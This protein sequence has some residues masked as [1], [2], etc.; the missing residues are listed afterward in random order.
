[1]MQFQMTLFKTVFTIRI[2]LQCARSDKL[3]GFRQGSNRSNLGNR[4]PLATVAH[5]Q[6]RFIL[7]AVIAVKHFPQIL[8]WT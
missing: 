5:N 1:M 2:F 4:I 8:K 3:Q 7:L 6:I